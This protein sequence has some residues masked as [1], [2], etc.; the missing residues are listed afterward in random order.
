[1]VQIGVAGKQVYTTV[2]P[3]DSRLE[4][5]LPCLESCLDSARH[6]PLSRFYHHPSCGRYESGPGDP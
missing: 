5:R 1:M 6:E 2:R 4:S 3:P